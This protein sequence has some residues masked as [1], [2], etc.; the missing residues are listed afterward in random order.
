MSNHTQKAFILA[1]ALQ[2][3]HAA[4]LQSADTKDK[5]ARE[6]A[7]SQYTAADIDAE[8][9]GTGTDCDDS[10]LEAFEVHNSSKPPA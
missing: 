1:H 8:E 2:Q 10:V 7:L 6:L 4:R 3:C 5:E 9:G